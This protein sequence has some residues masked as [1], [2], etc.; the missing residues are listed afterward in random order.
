MENV[1][2]EEGNMTIL[3]LVACLIA[4]LYLRERQRR[5]AVVAGA[6]AGAGDVPAP[7]LPDD[8]VAPPVP[9]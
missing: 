4:V 7:Q 3:T 5:H 9:N 6:R 1:L 8:H 2:L